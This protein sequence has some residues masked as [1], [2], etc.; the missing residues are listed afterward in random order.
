MGFIGQIN[1]GERAL[2]CAII[3]HA[4]D[5]FVQMAD[6][7]EA[8]RGEPFRIAENFLFGDGPVKRVLLRDPNDGEPLG[9]RSEQYVDCTL[10]RFAEMLTINGKTLDVK[11]IREGVIKKL[12]KKR[13]EKATEERHNWWT[14][15]N[16]QSG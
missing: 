13:R 7:P 1:Y 8:R 5:S 12:E 2:I 14:P 4:V 16:N 3:E 6:N 15:H 11:Y 9:E 10:K